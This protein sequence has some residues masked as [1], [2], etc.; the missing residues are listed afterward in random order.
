MNS[1]RQPHVGSRITKATAVAALIAISALS[2]PA[3]AFAMPNRL[4]AP[5]YAIDATKL[6]LQFNGANIPTSPADPK[7]NQ[8][9]L[10]A[11]Y[12]HH[13]DYDDDDDDNDYNYYY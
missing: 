13:P 12:G 7:C 8:V 3:H 9:R 6:S 1:T 10:P 4:N 2:A 11:S 5:D